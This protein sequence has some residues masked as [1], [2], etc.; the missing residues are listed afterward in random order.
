M[1]KGKLFIAGALASLAVAGADA[2][3]RDVS[4]T[5]SPL[6]EYNWWNENIQLKDSPFYG[7]RVGFGFGPFFE[8][9]GTF[10]KSLNLK[11]AIQKWEN[12]PL[13]EEA[14]N[15]LDGMK[16][17]VTRFGAEAKFN[18]LGNFDFSPYI[19]AGT[20]VQVFDYNPFDFKDAQVAVSDAKI[21]EKQLFVSLG[22]GL[23]M[24]LTDRIALSLEAKNIRFNMDA[25]NI[26][27]NPAVSN[28]TKRWGNWTGLASLDLYLGGNTQAQSDK[29]GRAY[30]SLF[31][32]GFRGPK[33]VIEPGVAYVDF[34]DK[35]GW[36]GQWYMGGSVGVDFSSLVG[37]RAFYYQATK[38]PNMLNFDF[39]KNL[40]M[41][42][43]N[44]IAR[45]NYPR[46]IVPYLKLGAGYIDDN[47]FIDAAVD[48]EKENKAYNKKNLFALA[49]AGVE[50]PMSRY[51]ALFGTVNSMLMT[52]RKNVENVQKPSD[53]VNNMMYTGGLRVN[54]GVPAVAPDFS[55]DDFDNDRI[56]EMRGDRKDDTRVED[57]RT[58]QERALFRKGEGCKK[59]TKKE[60]EE[61]VDR[62]LE[63][64]RNEE[65]AR[66]NN[67]SDKEMDVILT[68][69]NQEKKSDASNQEV[70]NEVRT[71]VQKLDRNYAVA[72][73]AAKG[74]TN[75]TTIITPGATA[76][77]PATTTV[78]P[79][80]NRT[81]TTAQAQDPQV[82]YNGETTAAQEAAPA[83]S[84]FLKLNRMAVITGV[85]F[86]ES[87]LWNLGVRGYM[88]IS[89][90]NFDFAPELFVG[91]GGK[92]GFGLSA[93]VLYN[94]NLENSP[95]SP[96]VGLGLGIFDHGLGSKAGANIIGGVNINNIANG[97][98]FVDYSSR[99]LFKNNMIAVGYRFV[100]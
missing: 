17:D 54:L 40:K 95:V 81:V 96:Y 61:M 19:T 76:T 51:F 21:K 97:A 20:G 29:Y 4:V 2:Q 92:T 45:L 48:S 12:Q 14:L 52:N 7:A 55:E 25:D 30:S 63:K 84:R 85:N 72:P 3:V 80:Q 39:N 11:N 67:F 15:K 65:S 26:Y 34:S 28:E 90:T 43:G 41:Y 6:I 8:L 58:R 59:M 77:A 69:L 60:F 70:I 98:L 82:I 64:I 32:D 47:N 49:G 88:Q 79:A 13:N 42:G 37:L 86:G 50:I 18:I 27:M 31:S 44:I 73:G 56:N 16:I 94:I 75:T 38:Q 71:L 66:A 100:F 62:I 23:K 78:I 5:L 46:G 57:S 87:T 9:R 53:L 74:S 10:E 91:M 99:N 93:N 24:S 36:R 68:A 1:K 35:L 83:D 22:A 89:N 33:F